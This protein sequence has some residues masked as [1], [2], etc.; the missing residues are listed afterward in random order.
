MVKGIDHEKSKYTKILNA[1]A[2]LG[3]RYLTYKPE[4]MKS[5]KLARDQ[6]YLENLLVN[7]E[8]KLLFDKE[9][10]TGVW[11]VRPEE[12]YRPLSELL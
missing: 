1:D 12:F 4:C 10:V 11:F 9:R 2:I 8:I 6:E 7:E 3:F 5:H